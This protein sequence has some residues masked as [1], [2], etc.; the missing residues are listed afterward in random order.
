MQARH[1]LVPAEAEVAAIPPAN[2]QMLA[3]RIERDDAL[4]PLAVAKEY[5][6]HAL[7]L[8]LQPPLQIHWTVPKPVLRH[9][10]LNVSTPGRHSSRT[11]G[12]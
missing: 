7:S 6:W 12:G 10:S 3:S 9:A 5:E 2:A 4:P 8:G 11:L 1:S